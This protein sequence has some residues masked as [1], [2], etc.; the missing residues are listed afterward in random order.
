[1]AARF[2]GVKDEGIEAGSG[3]G[4]GDGGPA[5]AAAGATAGVMREG[6]S[7]VMQ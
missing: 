6:R 4:S 5:G 3:S 7:M 2:E 1:M